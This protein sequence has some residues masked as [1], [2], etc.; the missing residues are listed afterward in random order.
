[1]SIELE[2]RLEGEDANEDTLLDLMDWLERADI[3]GLTIQRKT[4][5]PVEGYQSTGFDSTTFMIALAIPPAI[6]AIIQLINKVTEI[7]AQW[8]DE[9]DHNISIEPKLKNT[10]TEIEEIKQQI[11][12]ILDEMRQKC[13]KRK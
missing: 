3:D 12:A 6:V 11:Q 9:T 7:F 5:P 2:L 4:L 8:Q 10:G 13:Q 1:M